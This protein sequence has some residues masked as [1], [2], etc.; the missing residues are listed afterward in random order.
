VA[1]KRKPSTG[2]TIKA[3][4]KVVQYASLDTEFV[5]NN[6]TP[7]GLISMAIATEHASYYAV[8]ADMDT[9]QVCEREWMV[10]NVWKHIP[11]HGKGLLDYSHE[12]VKS[13]ETIRE[14]VDA[15]FRGLDLDPVE[16]VTDQLSIIVNHGSQDMI[17]LHTLWNNDW[18]QEKPWYIPTSPDDMGCIKRRLRRSP[19]G[20][21]V[22]MSLPVQDEAT[23]HHALHD[24]EHELSVVQHILKYQDI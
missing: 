15:F 22:E 17:R 6:L 8:N 20:R 11:N 10:E 2:K 9:R 14:E 18:H 21:E 7:T 1:G 12:D 13:Y 19:N 3:G 23:L 5:P 24:A 4:G 16:R